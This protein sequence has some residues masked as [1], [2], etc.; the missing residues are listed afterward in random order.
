MEGSSMT[1]FAFKPIQ[2][3]MLD[4]GCSMFNRFGTGLM[5]RHDGTGQNSLFTHSAGA[6]QSVWTE[7]GPFGK[8][9][10]QG[11]YPAQ[12]AS[13]RLEKKILFVFPICAPNGQASR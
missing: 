8:H 12:K 3:S 13:Q 5:C 10:L 4:V 6:N 2:Y 1:P 9:F 7:N 11:A